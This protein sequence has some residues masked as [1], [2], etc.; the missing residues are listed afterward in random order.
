[1]NLKF[2][3]LLYS[4]PLLLPCSTNANN[5]K[6]KCEW[7]VESSAEAIKEVRNLAQLKP[8]EQL[9]YLRDKKKLFVKIL[10]AQIKIPSGF[11]TW[12]Q[13]EKS[14]KPLNLITKNKALMGKTLCQGEH[15]ESKDG[16]TIVLSNNAPQ[17]TL[18]HEYLHT[19]QINNDSQWCSLSKTLW[20]TTNLDSHTEQI[21]RDKEWDVHK[22]LWKNKKLIAYDIEDQVT[23]ASET[24]EEAEM[25]KSWDPL[26]L[27][28]IKKEKIENYLNDKIIAYKKRL[29]KQLN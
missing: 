13:V 7:C 8:E 17:S 18:I 16:L 27:D 10:D 28:F 21:I 22:F 20:S 4:I 9:Q 2:S 24:I 29:N 1:M 15:T 3:L 6:L 11:F 26:A 5:K 25:R 14:T 12:G 19:L 23:I